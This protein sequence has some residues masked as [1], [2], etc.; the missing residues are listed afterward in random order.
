[1]GG[2]ISSA[3][4]PASNHTAAARGVRRREDLME[5]LKDRVGL[6]DR[7][8][9]A[10]TSGMTLAV[11]ADVKP[12]AT[13][14]HDPDGTT[15]SW[16]KVNA[17]ANRIVRLLRRHGPEGRRRRGAGLLQPRRVRR[18]AGRHP[19]RRLADHAGQLAPDRRRDR[20]HHQRLRGQGGVLRGARGRLEAGRRP[21]P[22]ACWSRSPSAAPIAGL[23]RLRRRARRRSTARTSTTRCWATP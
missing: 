19:A 10:A 11:W 18:G 6:D 14:I 9:A 23:P 1:M 2:F 8:A 15:H 16:G 20:L 13:F 7:L 22:R 21:V 3:P 4:P 17:Q 5:D 12:D